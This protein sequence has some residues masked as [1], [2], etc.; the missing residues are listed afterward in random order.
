MLSL[1]ESLPGFVA[2]WGP[3]LLIS[4]PADHDSPSKLLS[5]FEALEA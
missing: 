3:A 2:G 4:A 1:M 5:L